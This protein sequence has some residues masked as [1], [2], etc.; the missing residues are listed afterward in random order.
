MTLLFWIVVAIS[1]QLLLWL[2]IS[3]WRHWLAYMALKNRMTDVNPTLDN[4]SLTARANASGW[5]GYRTFRVARKEMEDKAESV[6]SFY[7]VPED[8]HPLEP[9][10]PGQ[11]LTFQLMLPNSDGEMETVTRCYSLSDAP[12]PNHYR[13]SVKRVVAPPDSAHPAGRVSNHF[14]NHIHPGSTLQLRAP[15]GHFYLQ[16][17]PH[18]VVL[19]AGGIGITPMLAMLNGALAT[20]S[21]HEIWLFYGVRNSNELIQTTQLKALAAA[22]PR[23]QLHLCFSHPLA[24]DLLGRDYH[25]KGRIDLPLL[26]LELPLKPF[27]FYVC[28]PS[29]MMESIVDGLEKWGVSQAHIHFEAFGP[30]TVKRHPITPAITDPIEITFAKTG[31]SIPW[32]TSAATLLEF[33]EAQGIKVNSGCRS[34]SCGSCQTTIIS[35]E[36][37]YL[38]QPDYDPQPGSCLLCCATPKTNLTLEA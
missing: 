3:F 24:D 17:Q 34:G 5:H 10:Y 13:I 22:H 37:N 33:A 19:I 4:S 1:L 27:H 32:Q 16:G 8:G 18:P 9:Y 12:H 21:D 36:I 20:P 2:G 38:H 26:R 15:G 29:A 6:C 30:A 11:Y 7:L 35:G 23:L 31:V 25:H 14:H 28:G